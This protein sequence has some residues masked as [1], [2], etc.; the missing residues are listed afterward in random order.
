MLKLTLSLSSVLVFESTKWY[1]KEGEMSKV[2]RL[3]L[4]TT[5][6]S[7]NSRENLSWI[8]INFNYFIMIRYS[9]SIIRSF[10]INIIT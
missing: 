7:F 10:V 3:T 5:W 6:S 9:F 1:K 8:L 2:P 4:T